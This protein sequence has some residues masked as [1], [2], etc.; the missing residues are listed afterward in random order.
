VYLNYF[1]HQ[2]PIPHEKDQKQT[3]QPAS[4]WNILM[5]F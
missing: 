2:K 5:N 3:Q 1:H 4:S